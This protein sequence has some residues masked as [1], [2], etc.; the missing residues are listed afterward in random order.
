MYNTSKVFNSTTYLTNTGTQNTDA[1]MMKNIEWGAVAYLKQSIYGLGLTDLIINSTINNTG[2]GTGDS[3]KTNVGQ[4]TTGNITGVYDM[5]GGAY[6]YVM[7]N[8]SKVEGKS[9]LSL[10]NLNSK[11]IDIYNCPGL[12]CSHLGDAIGETSGW[13]EDEC[14][15]YVCTN[16][17][18]YS[19]GGMQY[20]GQ[21]SQA[22]IFSFN[23]QLNSASYPEGDA[24]KYI[25]FRSVLVITG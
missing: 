24:H 7:G 11:Y 8:Y 3:Y 15:Y 17:P 23:A 25:T 9:S 21:S 22:G 4:S 18:W 12:T 6:E 2:G 5:S 14:T 16:D 19:R 1:H 13:Y 20:F 10:S